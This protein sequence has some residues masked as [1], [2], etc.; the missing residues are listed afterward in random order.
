MTAHSRHCDRALLL[1]FVVE[2]DHPSKRKSRVNMGLVCDSFSQF[3]I[4]LLLPWC[5]A[6]QISLWQ[7]WFRGGHL[8]LVTSAQCWSNIFSSA[9]GFYS[10]SSALS[11]DCTT[12]HI[13]TFELQVKSQRHCCARL[14]QM[15]SILANISLEVF[16][17]DAFSFNSL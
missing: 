1:Q 9:A 5:S 14:T 11:E 6:A 17:N 13:L 15:M 4:C 2:F 12:F 16:S 7:M 10:H 8:R 3:W